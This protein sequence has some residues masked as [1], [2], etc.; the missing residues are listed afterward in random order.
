MQRQRG[1]LAST[2]ASER[3]A[4]TCNMHVRFSAVHS[5]PRESSESG[6]GVRKDAEEGVVICHTAED[7]DGRGKEESGGKG[8]REGGGGKHDELVCEAHV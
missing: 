2:G 3:V 8:D 7:E 6:P 5:Q 4:V 1:G